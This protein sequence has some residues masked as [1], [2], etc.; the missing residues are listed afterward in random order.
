MADV[1]F[2]SEGYIFLAGDNNAAI[3]QHTG[4]RSINKQQ[5]AQWVDTTK[6]RKESLDALNIPFYMQ[7]VPD[8]HSVY[9]EYLPVSIVKDSKSNA[10]KVMS[11]LIPILNGHLLFAKADLIAAKENEQVYHKIDTHWTDRGAYVGYLQLVNLL[12][13]DF[14][15]LSV[16]KKPEYLKKWFGGDL[17]AML[18]LKMS[19]EAELLVE[20][21]G[22]VEVFNNR[23]PV[24]GKI[25]VYENTCVDNDLVLL[26]FGGSSTVNFLKFITYSFKMVI[27]CWSGVLDYELIKHYSPDIVLNQIRERF[28]IRPANDVVGINPSEAA[29]IKAFSSGSISKLGLGEQKNI[30][31]FIQSLV[32]ISAIENKSYINDLKTLSKRLGLLPLFLYASSLDVCDLGYDKLYSI[33]HSRFEDIRNEISNS[34]MF[35][36]DFVKVAVNK[37]QLLSH[38]CVYTDYLMCGYLFDFKSSGIFNGNSYLN[39]YPDVESAG[40]NPLWHYERHGK[41]EGRSVAVS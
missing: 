15:S 12:S 8:K 31:L 32:K 3:D 37:L 27:F 2:G 36:C 19:S 6:K 11:A 22:Y 29:F 1:L 9:S 20:H 18:P 23:V 13:K 25:Q 5:V 35:D 14:P 4:K 21:D 39:E 16:L 28:L 24:T 41:S 10:S 7:I 30:S 38:D 40:M 17:G 33:L 34:K 26:I